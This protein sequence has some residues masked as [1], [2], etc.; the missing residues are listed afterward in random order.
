LDELIQLAKQSNHAHL[1][2]INTLKTKLHISPEVLNHMVPDFKQRDC[3]ACGAA[4]MM[5]SIEQLYR[6]FKLSDI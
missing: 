6:E 1:H 4:P 5:Q 3:Y 2:A